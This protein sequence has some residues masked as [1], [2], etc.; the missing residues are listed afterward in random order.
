MATPPKYERVVC[1]FED[2]L[3]T[4]V[5]LTLFAASVTAA[6]AGSYAEA[7][8]WMAEVP[9][10]NPVRA[11]LLIPK[12]HDA[13]D[14]TIVREPDNVPA[15]LDLVRFHMV[16]PSLLGGDV[17]EAKTQ[18]NEI[19]RRDVALGHFARGYIAYRQKEYGPARHDLR[20]AMR[21]GNAS[22]RALAARWLGWL[23][24]E[25]QQ[26][27][28]AFAMFEELGA[29]YEIGRTASFCGCR[30]ER[31]KAALR[32]YLKAKP[33]DPDAKKVLNALERRRP[34]G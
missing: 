3:R 21:L 30:L 24:Q 23:S 33:K 10:T 27:D 6:P 19:A 16:T 2:C 17:D 32:Q 22:T 34:A 12:I 14:A 7:K 8:R 11:L 20:D 4:F 5:L 13:L 9:H 29:L 26:W 28:E 18:A 31:G 15:R 25:T 1:N